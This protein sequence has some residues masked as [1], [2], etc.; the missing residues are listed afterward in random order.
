MSPDRLR[1]LALGDP[2]SAAYRSVRDALA[3]YGALHFRRE[4]DFPKADDVLGYFFE[5]G[6]DL[7]TMPNPYG[8]ERRRFVYTLAREAGAPLVT[9][10]RG[11]L[12]DSWFFDIG[13]NADSPTYSPLVWDRPLDPDEAAAVAGYIA[14]LRASDRA[15][16]A[17]GPREPAEAVRARL[18]LGDSKV[19]FVPFQRPE[20]TTVRFFSGHARSFRHF[21]GEIETAAAL[22]DARG[23]GWTV[24]AKTH[25]LETSPP[26]GRLRLAPP[27]E[28]VSSLL[29]VADAVACINSGV[30]LLAA[31]FGTPVFHFGSVYYG[32]PKLNAPVQS[33]HALVHALEAGPPTVCAETRDR[34]FHHL[35]KRVYSFG[36]AHTRVAVEKNGSLRRI[37]ERI[38]FSE[39]RLPEAVKKK[40]CLYLTPVIPDQVNR[41]SVVRTRQTLRAIMAAGYLV[42]LVVLNRSE[43]GASSEE[44]A[45][46]LREAFPGLASV[47][48]RRHPMLLRGRRRFADRWRFA[49]HRAGALVDALVLGPFRIVSLDEQPAALRRLVARKVRRD[50]YDLV[51]ANYA[52]MTPK[53][54]G[55]L[56]ALT[57]VDT[58]DV[59]SDRVSNDGVLRGWRLE[60]F[61]RSER[62]TLAAYDR[63][64]AITEADRATFARDFGLGDRVVAL[65]V[66]TA[67][68]TPVK[69]PASA[70]WDLLFVGS[71]ST[72]NARAMLWFLSAVWPD[73]AARGATLRIQGRVCANSDVRRVLAA[74]PALADRVGLNLYAPDLAEVYAAARLVIAPLTE[75]TGMKVKVVE[76]LSYGK[77]VLGTPVAFEGIAVTDG[78]D[79]AIADGAEAFAARAA[80]LLADA[81]AL[82]R[83]GAGAR[84]LFERAH[85]EAESDRAMAALLAPRR[86]QTAA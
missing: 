3:A 52:K 75:G 59:Q 10:D 21:V 14:A 17:Q 67:T 70:C 11:G 5:N 22:L 46:R 1:V 8:N 9:F 37:T 74:Q 7:M 38:D 62:R 12:P 26:S 43:P 32:H 2:R 64:L 54:L 29:E 55:R 81:A 48:V 69:S 44:I 58:H 68:P 51:F 79:S 53:G 47:S 27:E 18:G 40:T 36:V 6:F 31:A 60:T 49:L 20:D 30:G 13:F 34:L 41:G 66:A 61:R 50:A 65:P 35:T 33:A 71:N 24:I 86:P 84:A 56:R 77:A 42:D 78:V 82:S 76:A 80:A 39:L 15:L 4:Q 19:L 23:S 16:E 73:L 25:P 63:V 85:G 28:H 57:V 72:A 45:R 83:L